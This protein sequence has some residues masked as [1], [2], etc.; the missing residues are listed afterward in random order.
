M[1]F[2]NIG[3]LPR[4]GFFFIRAQM[5]ENLRSE[6]GGGVQEA[7]EESIL[8][9]IARMKERVE[10]DSLS[11][12]LMHRAYG[13]AC[14]SCGVLWIRSSASIWNVAHACIHET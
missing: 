11:L 8:G 5:K 4:F 6:R 12:L 13:C 9:Q 2:F 1:E 7:W 3:P 10:V 14:M